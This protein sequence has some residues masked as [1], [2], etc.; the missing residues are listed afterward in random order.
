MYSDHQFSWLHILIYI[1][2]KVCFCI[3]YF[4]FTFAAVSGMFW[5]QF[6][7]EPRTTEVARRG[8][9][10]VYFRHR[11]ILVGSPSQRNKRGWCAPKKWHL[12]KNIVYRPYIYTFIYI[13][14][15]TNK[16]RMPSK[17]AIIRM[18]HSTNYSKPRW[19]IKDISPNHVTNSFHISFKWQNDSIKWEISL[20]WT[21]CFQRLFVST[22]HNNMN[23][24]YQT[25]WIP[26]SGHNISCVVT[27]N[28]GCNSAFWT[29]QLYS[30]FH[31]QNK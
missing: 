7:L 22:Q 21:P 5:H 17:Q 10:R 28:F 14:I 4:R 3:T 31:N 26:I 27:K 20:F 6:P 9:C 2:P 30:K 19:N 11:A 15:Y 23:L 24:F 13:Y 29:K 12:A 16:Y 8:L 25:W 1:P 18:T